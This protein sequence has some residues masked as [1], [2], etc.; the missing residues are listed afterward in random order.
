MTQ[1]FE[2]SPHRLIAARRV[3][4]ASVYNRQGDKL[5]HVEDVFI[6]KRSG[7]AEFATLAYGGVLGVGEKQHPLPWSVLNY[8]PSA[9][10][11]VVDLD[12]KVLDAAP[13]YDAE[14]LA[15]EDRT[16]DEEVRNYFGVA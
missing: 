5:G 2:Q 8:D 14:R 4:G 11:Y 10:G 13:A 6:D 16:W 1:G 9:G 15:G 3:E 7:Q 12:K